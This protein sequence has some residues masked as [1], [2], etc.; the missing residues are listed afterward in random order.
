MESAG[1]PPCANSSAKL[2]ARGTSTNLSRSNSLTDPDVPPRGRRLL[3]RLLCLVGLL[4]DEGFDA[5]KFLLES[6]GK[7]V[8]SVLEEHDEAEGEKDKESEP[9]QS[10]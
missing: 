8:R 7:V 6:I 1:A 9:K 4:H 2:T 10:A 3:L 5:A